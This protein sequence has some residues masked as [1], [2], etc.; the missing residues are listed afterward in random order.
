MQVIPTLRP[1]VLKY[2][3]RACFGLCGA[4]GNYKLVFVHNRVDWDM[5]WPFCEPARTPALPTVGAAMLAHTMFPCIPMIS[6]IVSYVSKM[7][8]NDLGSCSGLYG[9]PPFTDG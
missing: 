5:F 2:I 1:K 9:R 8:Q 4:P 7:L 6:T 3:N